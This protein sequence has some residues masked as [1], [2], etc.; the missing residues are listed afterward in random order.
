MKAGTEI[1]I[2]RTIR[3]IEGNRLTLIA[4]LTSTQFLDEEPGVV[5]KTLAVKRL[6][7]CGIESLQIVSPS[8]SGTLKAGER[9]PVP[10]NL[11]NPA[12]MY[13]T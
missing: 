1:T 5:I 2:H 11:V 7:Q 6:S 4:P 3:A 12:S 13:L 10:L 8:H 9:I